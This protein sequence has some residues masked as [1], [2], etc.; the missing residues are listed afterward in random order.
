[1][2]IAWWLERASDLY[3]E[4]TALVDGRSGERWTYRELRDRADSVGQVL[5]EE[6]GVGAGDIVATLMPDDCWHT[7]IFYGVLR[8]G[9]VFSGFNRTLGLAKF[10]ADIARL[11]AKTLIVGEAQLD[12]GRQLLEETGLERVL[13][14]AAPGEHGVPNLRELAAGRGD[15]T[16]PAPRTQDDLAAIN[17]TGGTSGVSKGVMFPHGRLTLSAQ[18]SL[19]FDKLRETDVN[20]SCIS[21]YHSGGIHDAVKWVM[22]GAAVVLT[23]GWDADLAARLITEHRPTWIYFWVPTMVRDLMRH[24]SWNELPLSGLRSIVSGENVPVDLQATLI[25]RGIVAQN[26]YGMT[27]TMPVGILKPLAAHG[28][29]PPLGSSGR[30]L[31]ELC[32]T[33]LFDPDTGNRITEPFVTGEVCVRG[34]VVSPGYYNDAE[35]T[36]AAIDADGWLHTRDVA[37]FDEQGWWFLGGRTDDIINSGA[38]KLSL[39]EVEDVLRGHDAVRDV[40]CVPVEHERFGH[41]PAA[42]VA[43]TGELSDAEAAAALDAHCIAALERWKRPRLYRVVSEVP[44]TMPK[45]TKDLG[46]LRELVAGTR[47]RDADGVLG[48]SQLPDPN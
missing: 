7:A 13:V 4:R 10:T 25:E 14:S 9:G 32:E 17:F 36:G 5:R 24:P 46:A 37:S 19:L 2:N 31:P 39:L 35:R 43:L 29:Q 42:I 11:D 1:M 16:Q 12:I 47:L 38:E 15:A 18:A 21:L 3:G 22:A 41:V 6:Y 44:R 20:L 28:D 27:E 34:D 26:S 8:I 48:W 30:P 33:A 40:A 23:G 45:R